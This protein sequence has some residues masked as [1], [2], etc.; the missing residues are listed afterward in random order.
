MIRSDS[1]FHCHCHHFKQ[2]LKHTNWIVHANCNVFS[3]RTLLKLCFQIFF[4]H[5]NL[6][7]E[8]FEFCINNENVPFL[9]NKVKSLDKS[10]N[11]GMAVLLC[12]SLK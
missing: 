4:N 3:F 7:M 10:K 9:C 2:Q 8:D 5:F 11:R 12:L 1:N 6:S